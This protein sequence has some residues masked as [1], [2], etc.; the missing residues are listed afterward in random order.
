VINYKLCSHR[1]AALQVRISSEAFFSLTLSHRLP[2]PPITP[3]PHPPPPTP[4]P[5]SHH[6]PSDHHSPLTPH[7]PLHSPLH[8]PPLSRAL[9]SCR[10][11]KQSSSS[12]CTCR[13]F[14]SASAWRGP[15]TDTGGGLA[16]ST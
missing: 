8:P 5:P 7:P 10:V 13:C 9:G 3:S 2:F 4:H 14:V 11:R 16:G 12:R 6:H 1:M 15:S